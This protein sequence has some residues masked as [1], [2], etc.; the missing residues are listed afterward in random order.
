MQVVDRVAAAGWLLT[1]FGC[2]LGMMGLSFGPETSPCLGR[3]S[4]TISAVAPRHM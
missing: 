4:V 1:A 2:K 3:A